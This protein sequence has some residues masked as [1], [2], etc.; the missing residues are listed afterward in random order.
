MRVCVSKCVATKLWIRLHRAK[1]RIKRGLDYASKP[2]QQLLER[3]HARQRL[4]SFCRIN[5]VLLAA[6]ADLFLLLCLCV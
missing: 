4:M 2:E 5:T 3:P 6:T 1:I